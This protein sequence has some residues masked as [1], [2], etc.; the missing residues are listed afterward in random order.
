MH[1]KLN[2]DA[3]CITFRPDDQP[4][5]LMI[6]DVPL[7]NRMEARA[8]TPAALREIQNIVKA[9]CNLKWMAGKLEDDGTR[10]FQSN[11]GKTHFLYIES[12]RTRSAVIR[13]QLTPP[14]GERAR[15]H[16]KGRRL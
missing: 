15:S 1:D 12:K 6:S 3:L 4:A 5:S 13:Q 14:I 2:Y 11:L 7:R 9:I 16:W 10:L 8:E